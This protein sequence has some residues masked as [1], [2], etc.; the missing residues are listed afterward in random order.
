MQQARKNLTEYELPL[1]N[2]SLRRKI[3]VTADSSK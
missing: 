2:L 1:K 3:P